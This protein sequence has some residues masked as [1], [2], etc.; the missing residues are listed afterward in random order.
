MALVSNVMAGVN[1]Y[2]QQAFS[3]ALAGKYVDI[4]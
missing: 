2:P 4:F 3:G 1:S